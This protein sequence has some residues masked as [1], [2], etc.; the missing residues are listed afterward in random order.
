MIEELTQSDAGHRYQSHAPPHFRPRVCLAATSC[1]LWSSLSN[2]DLRTFGE[3]NVVAVTRMPFGRRS[4]EELCG[5]A[6]FLLAAAVPLLP[7]VCSNTRHTEGSTP[8]FC[9]NH[10]NLRGVSAKS[11]S[12]SQITDD[13]H[14]AAS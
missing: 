4:F 3:S 10:S 1:A 5:G 6:C 2:S 14:T 8:G 9:M 11:G 12:G 13:Q 7:A